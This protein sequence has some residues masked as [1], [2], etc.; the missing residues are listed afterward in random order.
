MA[1]KP[2]IN[3]GVAVAERPAS[4][5]SAM[6]FISGGS[7]LG[8]S[9][10]SAAANKIVGFQRGAAAVAPRAPDLG[11]IIK[12]LST[13]ILSNVENRV[14][15]INQNVR[16]FIQKNFQ[17][18]LGEYREKMQ[19]VD[20]N[21]PSKILQNFLG[22][23]EKA[24]GY[25]QFFANPR[26]V[27]QLGQNL[28]DLRNVFAETFE[29]AK[30]IRKT[31][32]RIV[33]QLS[34]LPT[35]SAGG[36][37]INLDV[38][39]PGARLKKDGAPLRR[40]MGGAKGLLAAGGL[41]LGAGL[42]TSA[43]AQPGS[44]Q[45]TTLGLMGGE[46][47]ISQPLLEK[48]SAILDRFNKA[49]KSMSKSGTQQESKKSTSSTIPPKQPP[50]G[51]PGKP[52]SP[53]AP[54]APGV[55]TTGERGVLDLIGSVEAK[56]YDVFNQ[57][58]GKT[59]GKATEKTIGW[60]AQNAKGAIG[61]YQ[62]IPRYLL[63]RAKRAGFDE[64][65]KFTPE[66]QDAITLNELR[67][68]YSMNEFLSGKI[69]EEQFLSKISP[70]WRGLPQGQTQAAKRGGTA[71]MTLQDSSASRNKAH[72]TYLQVIGELKAIRGSGN[73]P[74]ATTQPVKPTPGVAA[75][76]T[77]QQIQQET[78]QQVSR[79]AIVQSTPQTTIAPPIT[80]GEQGSRGIQKPPVTSAGRIS[81]ESS[82]PFLPTGNPDNFLTLYSKM[83]Y[84]IVDG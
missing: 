45:E 2:F 78:A 80:M 69:S 24:I 66:V 56:N 38:D 32:V 79:P 61:R 52:G 76:S 54:G 81:G 21:Q 43:L 65:T 22:L 28:R 17:S 25:M 20:A 53:G 83:V 68:G 74:V 71:D 50:P 9:V 77:Q 72:K 47:T 55:T 14:Q 36:G 60:L 6:N 59:P 12:T 37:G 82:V 19:S 1:I 41:G 13:N 67:K 44:A 10:V 73:K 46:G 58:A 7:P 63:E 27:K 51:D 3:P 75:A 31:I 39:L 29:V 35:A 48:F 26:N 62:H 4:I 70:V 84:N 18:Q 8:S 42:V 30:N 11:S 15:S 34:N 57:S 5:S 33:G 16:Q 49:I 23:Y 64:N 40:R